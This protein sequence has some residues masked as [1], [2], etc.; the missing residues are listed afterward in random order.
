MTPTEPAAF[1]SIDEVDVPDAPAYLAYGIDTGRETLDV[2]PDDAL[3]L[4]LQ[5]GQVAADDSG[6]DR[7]PDPQARRPSL[8]ERLLAARFTQRRQARP[9]ALDQQGSAAARLVLGRQPTQLA[10]LRVVRGQALRL[11]RA[12]A[13][14]D[15]RRDGLLATAMT[16]SRSSSAT[17]SVDNLNACDEDTAAESSNQTCRKIA[18]PGRF[19]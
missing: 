11:R 5:A 4:I 13:N 2:T 1:Q 8:G 17:S 19:R 18:Y 7:R 3:P 6:G 12:S 9:R 16:E 15:W 10:R 14:R